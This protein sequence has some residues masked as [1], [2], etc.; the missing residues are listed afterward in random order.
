MP[1]QQILIQ[2]YS[3]ILRMNRIINNMCALHTTVRVILLYVSLLDHGYRVILLRLFIL[4][5]IRFS[6]ELITT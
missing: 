2:N 5:A 1:A 6:L 4:L 3:V